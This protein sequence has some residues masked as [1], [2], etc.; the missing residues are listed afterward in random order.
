MLTG[1]KIKVFMSEA[2]EDGKAFGSWTYFENIIRIARKH[3]NKTINKEKQAQTFCHEWVH[4]ALDHYG[5]DDL[6]GNEQLVDNLGS[7]LYELMRTKK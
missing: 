2:V 4:A 6:S 5:W 7:A 3:H 1:Q